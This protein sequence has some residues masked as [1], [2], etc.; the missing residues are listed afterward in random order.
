MYIREKRLRFK[1]I[2]YGI[3][4]FMLVNQFRRVTK[5]IEE[6]HDI[7][8]REDVDQRTIHNSLNYYQKEKEILLGLFESCLANTITVPEKEKEDE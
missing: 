5:K 1:D 2:G 4:F 3:Q 7:K 6:L 8:V